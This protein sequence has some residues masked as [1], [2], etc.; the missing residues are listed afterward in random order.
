MTLQGLPLPV[1]MSSITCACLVNTLAHI[2]R[3]HGMRLLSSLAFGTCSSCSTAACAVQ[4]CH[5]CSLG[6]TALPWPKLDMGPSAII[7]IVPGCSP[8][9][10]PRVSDP[11]PIFDE[12]EPWRLVWARQASGGTFP[13]IPSHSWS[14]WSWFLGLRNGPDLQGTLVQGPEFVCVITGILV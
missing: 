14:L 10:F 13:V 3:S 11:I 7:G 9:V 6:F 4:H 12:Q 2:P 5:V 1:Q 8:L